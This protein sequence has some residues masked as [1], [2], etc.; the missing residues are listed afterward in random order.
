MGIVGFLNILNKAEVK[1]QVA[2]SEDYIEF[3][4]C[5]LENFHHYYFDYF[6][7]DNRFLSTSLDM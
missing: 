4:S 6:M 7:N 1:N 2:I 5:L 3:N